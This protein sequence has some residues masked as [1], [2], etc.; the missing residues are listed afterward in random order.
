VHTILPWNNN[1]MAQ[2]NCSFECCF[3]SSQKV[4]YVQMARTVHPNQWQLFCGGNSNVE[5]F[6]VLLSMKE[7]VVNSV[8]VGSR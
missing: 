5:Q 6:I 4:C 2:K 8:V 7:E 1:Y 3:E